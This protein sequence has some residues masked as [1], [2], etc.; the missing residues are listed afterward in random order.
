LDMKRP[1]ALD[2][3][4]RLCAAS[5]I[6]VENFAAGVMDL[7]GLGYD[8]LRTLRPDVI[9]I[10]LSGYG[11]SGPDHDKVSYGPAQVPLSGMSSLTGSRDFPPMHVG[12]SYGAPTGGL[13]GAVAVLAALLHR[14]K[15]GQGQY[16]DLSQWE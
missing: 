3:A 14:A 2:V 12:V 7:M 9:M 5:D 13:H 1:E 10:A 8:V 11:A 4:K 16:I 6:V 15:T